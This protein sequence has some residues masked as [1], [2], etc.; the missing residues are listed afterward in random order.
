MKD[1]RVALRYAKAILSLAKN[2]K[3]ESEINTDMQFIAA[4]IS[5][6]KEFEMLLKSPVVKSSDKIKVLNA[7]FSVKVHKITLDLFKVL[8]E[9]KRIAILAPVAMQYSVLYN[10]FKNIQIAKVTTAIA[11]SKEVEAKVLEKVVALTGSNALIENE[12]NPAILGGFILRVGDIQ[13][14]ASISHNLKELKK[15]FDNN[16]YVPKI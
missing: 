2:T 6:N 15:E 1:A 3:A 11:L 14:D 12:V 13:Y 9:N 4:T 5:E 16:H 7:L 10:K 8:Q